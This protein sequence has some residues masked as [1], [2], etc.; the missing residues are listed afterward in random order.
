M[1]NTRPSVTLHSHNAEHDLLSVSIVTVN[2]EYCEKF[3]ATVWE[4]IPH[5][6]VVATGCTC[7][8]ARARQLS[9]DVTADAYL[10]AIKLAC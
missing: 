1:I 2:S 4:L 9:R 8:C 7:M 5:G 10:C 3:G 6:T